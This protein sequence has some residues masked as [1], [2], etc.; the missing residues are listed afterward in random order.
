MYDAFTRWNPGSTFR[1]SEDHQA[2]AQ[3]FFRDDGTLW[4]QSGA[5]RW[6]SGEGLF[7]S[8]DVYDRQG[9]FVQRVD[10]VADADAAEDGLFFV[11]DRAYVVTDLWSAVMSSVGGDGSDAFGDAEPVTVISYEFDPVVAAAR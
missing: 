2:V 11:G 1:I 10:L 5:Q 4:V 6:R 3:L 8:F 7:T 9:G